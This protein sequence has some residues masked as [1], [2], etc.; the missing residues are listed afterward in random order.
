M[1]RLGKMWRLLRAEDYVLVTLTKK[2]HGKMAKQTN[3]LVSRRNQQHKDEI[4]DGLRQAVMEVK[5]AR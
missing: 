1:S 4:V 2:K 3:I 5:N